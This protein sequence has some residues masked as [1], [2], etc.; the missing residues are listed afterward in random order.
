MLQSSSLSRRGHRCSVVMVVAPLL[1]HDVPS[2]SN[3]E[4]RLCPTQMVWLELFRVS[5]LPGATG[6]PPSAWRAVEISPMLINASARSTLFSTVSTLVPSG[7]NTC[8]TFRRFPAQAQEIN[9]LSVRKFL[10]TIKKLVLGH[11]ATSFRTEQQNSG[12]QDE[13]LPPS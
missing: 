1:L 6:D 4:I 13:Q 9:P 8:C 11:F 12:K 3:E 5:S 7:P 10:E 2:S